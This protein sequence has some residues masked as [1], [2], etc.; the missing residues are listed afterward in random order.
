MRRQA[1]NE[2]WSKIRQDMMRAQVEKSCPPTNTCIRCSRFAKFIVKCQDCGPNVYMCAPCMN[3]QHDYIWFH[4]PK[5][6]NVSMILYL[7]HT[8]YV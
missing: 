6:W 8:S 4:D 1:Q 7:F 5:V 2:N 3:R